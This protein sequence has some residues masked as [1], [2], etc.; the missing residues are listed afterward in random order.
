MRACAVMRRGFALLNRVCYDILSCNS[1]RCVY[2]GANG[3]AAAPLF[4]RRV[5]SKKSE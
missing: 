3:R 5:R 4:S 2:G 1:Q